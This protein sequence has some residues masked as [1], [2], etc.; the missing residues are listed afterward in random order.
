MLGY[1]TKYYQGEDPHRLFH[2]AREEGRVI[3]TRDSKLIPKRPGDR[4]IRIIEDKP[5]LQVKELIKKGLI[6][7]DESKI[8]SRCLICNLLIT[9]IP[10]EEAEGRVPDFIFYQ[11]K[12]F[13]KCPRCGRVYWHGS[14]KENMQKRIE[15]LF[16]VEN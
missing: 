13:Y 14:H 3:L 15:E 6:T 11:K 12:D 2:I 8:F 10:L 7:I 5:F 1:D 16:K 9:E 4:I